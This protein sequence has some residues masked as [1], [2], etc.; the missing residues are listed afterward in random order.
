MSSIMPISSVINNLI[1]AGATQTHT[2]TDEHR[3][4][5]VLMKGIIG[6]SVREFGGLAGACSLLLEALEIVPS[7]FIRASQAERVNGF[8]KTHLK[9]QPADCLQQVHAAGYIHPASGVDV[10]R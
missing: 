6:S 10:R 3:C 2:H 7:P 4:G 1:S 9:G 8:D 5:S